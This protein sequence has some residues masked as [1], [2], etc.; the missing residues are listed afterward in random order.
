MHHIPLHTGKTRVREQVGEAHYD[1]IE[2]ADGEGERTK[3]VGYQEFEREI[4]RVN[5]RGPCPPALRRGY[6]AH[7]PEPTTKNRNTQAPC[8]YYIL[9]G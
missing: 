9:M 7:R 3:K 5:S 8:S 1:G 2:L 6:D 4:K